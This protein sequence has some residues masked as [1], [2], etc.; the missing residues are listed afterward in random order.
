MSRK[1]S[2]IL[3]PRPGG[4]SAWWDSLKSNAPLPLVLLLLIPLGRFV[5]G[6]LGAYNQ[7]IVMLVGVNII[8]AV[9][10][11]LINGFSGQFS[12]GHAGFMA[13]GAY[14]AAYP[15]LNYS[16]RYANAGAPLWFFVSLGV[17]ALLVGGTV[18]GMFF[19]VR[20]SRKI[21][22]TLPA[23]AILLLFAWLLA[24]VSIESGPR[25][26]AWW[27][28]W[29]RAFE[30]IGAMFNAMMTSGVPVATKLSASIPE[31][32][33]APICF[34][35]VIIGAGCCAAATGF[36]IGLPALRLRG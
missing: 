23:I 28:V 6:P 8:L 13:V 32:A 27:L 24:D 30:L 15:A 2:D 22:S 34:L 36:I 33:R 11:Q 25:R 3:E 26:G 7:R 14:L 10:L 16:E 19:L 17:V 4:H 1:K 21:H 12:L 29:S 31:L 5:E 18:Y 20:L 9:S 35:I